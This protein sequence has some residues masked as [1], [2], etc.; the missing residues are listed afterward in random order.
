MIGGSAGDLWVT[1]LARVPPAAAK[2]QR[3]QAYT[4]DAPGTGFRHLLQFSK[5]AV[6]FPVGT[7]REIEGVRTSERTAVAE[8]QPP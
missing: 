1:R 5:Q 7:G 6:R 2:H 8:P 3:K 4:G